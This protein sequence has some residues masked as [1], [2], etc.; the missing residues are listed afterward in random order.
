MST[1]TDPT[2]P[3]APADGSS[4]S[5]IN[6]LLM[7]SDTRNGKNG[8]IGGRVTR[9]MRNDTTI[10]MHISA[11]R[12]RVE[13]IS[14]PRD[15]RVRIPDCT[16]FDGTTVLGWTGKFNIAFSNGG[17]RGDPAEAAAC[18]Q[19]AVEDLTGI[20]IHYYAVVD[21]YGF[22]K[23][24]DS[25]GGV[26]MCIPFAIKAHKSH[27]NVKAGPQVLNGKTALAWARTRTVDSSGGYI[28]GSDIQRIGRQQ[29]LLA[30]VAETVIEQGI[31][32]KP[33]ELADFLS[34]GAEYM[35]M[36]P[37][38]AD[39]NYLVGLAFSLRDLDK[40][41]IT[42]VTV[43]WRYTTDG[44]DVEWT[45]DAYDLFKKVINDKPIKGKTVASV[46]DVAKPQPAPSASPGA[47]PAPAPTTTVDT[48]STDYL[49][50]ACDTGE[51]KEEV[52]TRAAAYPWPRPLREVR[53]GTRPS[54]RARAQQ[55]RLAPRQ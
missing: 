8:T 5:A 46:S 54:A 35:T 2:I 37:K 6:I 44:S 48:S 14:I 47:T 39:I 29:D 19:N 50:G 49:L 23:M 31:M 10:I 11:D 52:T 42:F 33:D 38:L 20:Y 18:T 12:S 40:K 13:L 1:P 43:P 36:D 26:P 15:S 17:R 22:E 4:G 21:F 32:F 53:P 16:L 30:K 24:I 3:L 45:S 25:I 27:L 28:D 7:G 41:N 9:G 55:V 34:S 51:E